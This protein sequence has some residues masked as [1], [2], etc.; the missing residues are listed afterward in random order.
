M[1]WREQDA[2][3]ARRGG[4]RHH[5]YVGVRQQA[6]QLI[7][8]VHAV[9]GGV[10]GLLR[11]ADAPYL[12]GA[13]GLGPAG[14][15][16]ADVT[17]TQHGDGAADDGAHG[18]HRPPAV[19]VSVAHIGVGVAQQHQRDHDEMLGDGDAEAPEELL[20]TTS[21]EGYSASSR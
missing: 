1:R 7:V 18:Y 12:P 10:G 4:Q 21:G 13:H 8:G 5:Q 11:P 15:L 9:K 17:G 20:S 16:R 3:G 6:V 2:H 19:G 14:K